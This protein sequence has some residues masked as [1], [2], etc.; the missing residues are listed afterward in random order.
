MDVI[1]NK[2][3][4][5][6]INMIIYLIIQ[7]T[8]IFSY[9]IKNNKFFCNKFVVLIYI[10]PDSKSVLLIFLFTRYLYRY[11]YIKKYIDINYIYNSLYYI[12]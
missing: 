12:T 11:L 9:S 4:H 5:K 2:T 8:V 7:T 10:Y 1:L 3:E 6:F